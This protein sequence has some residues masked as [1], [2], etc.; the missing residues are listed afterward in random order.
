[1]NTSN[2]SKRSF[3]LAG[4]LLSTFMAAIE[5]TV[6]GP[7][8]PA[9]VGSFGSVSLMS[10][11]FT[12]YLLTMAV[13]TPIFGKIS[14]LYGRKPVFLYGSLLFLA[15]SLLCGFSQ[16]MTQLIL[17][18][19]IQGIGAGAVIPVTF[20][21]IGDIYSLK[22]RGKVQ[23]MLSS[24]WGISSLVGPLMGGYFVDYLSWRWIFGFNAPFA[25]ISIWF[26]YRY[27]DEKREPRKVQIDFAG[28]GLFT[29]GMTLLLFALAVG[30]EKF[31]WTSPA[32]L[33]I[34][35]VSVVLLT[36]F[37]IVE[38][39]AQE[40]M[41]PLQLFRIK[42]IS[43]STIANL[44]VSA[45]LIGLTTYLP[46]WI[47]GVR[48]GNATMSGL[49]LA[50]MSIGWLFGSVASGRLITKAG[51]RK[52]ALIG[53]IGLVIGAG[54]LAFVHEST[55]VAALLIYTFIYGLG[56]GYI[57]TL[58]SIIAQSSVGYEMRGASTALN[59]FVRTLGQTVGVAVFGTW[60]NTSIARRIAAEPAGSGI[61][62]EDMN[63]LLSPHGDVSLPGSSGGHLKHV[64]EGSL[65][66][67]FIV[68][69]VIALACF[70]IVA[71]YNNRPPMP[72]DRGGEEERS[73]SA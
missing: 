3:I 69:A 35:A 47:Q 23:G 34:L 60:L 49:T 14:D 24:V 16:S 4:I 32:M 2:H 55:P 12:S 36:A 19:A 37:L 68:M 22:E 39:R 25:L 72:E 50:P 33:A 61:S 64:L 40:P 28:A 46:L 51:S 73:V 48:G 71:R 26:I 66:S 52:T 10:W 53:V 67:L 11:I 31:P 27:L 17:F 58:F 20:T 43:V 70:A 21:I 6:V 29:V 45:L 63:K 18:R 8:G 42:D 65:N 62:R 59:T 30:G 54:G 41:V 56:F 5:G 57:S 44:L 9:I 13:T 7:A 1:M 15:G 38:A